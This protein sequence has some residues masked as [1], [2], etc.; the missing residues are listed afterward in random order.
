V[1]TLGKNTDTKEIIF[2]IH[3]IKRKHAHIHNM[4]DFKL[5]AVEAKCRELLRTVDVETLSERQIR[6]RLAQD[7]GFPVDDFKPLIVSLVDEF[8]HEGTRGRRRSAPLPGR[9]TTTT[10]DEEAES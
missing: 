2:K 6:E 7:L 9:T 1:S 4:S 10:V 3:Q 8:V 5:A